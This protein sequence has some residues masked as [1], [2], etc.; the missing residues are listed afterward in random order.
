MLNYRHE[1]TPPTLAQIAI[2]SASLMVSMPTFASATRTDIRS[3]RHAVPY[4]IIASSSSY[5]P[6]ATS[7][8]ELT[9]DV[10]ESD[11]IGSITKFYASLLERQQPLGAEFERV[12]YDNLWDLY[13]S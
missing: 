3:E 8:K 13:E 12:L 11:F 7:I 5:G 9:G 1:Q 10:S 6:V 4:S 2:V